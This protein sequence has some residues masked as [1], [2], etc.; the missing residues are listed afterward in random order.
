MTLG[1]KTERGDVLTGLR[2][3]PLS[4]EDRLLREAVQSLSL[5]V[6]KTGLDEAL[7]NLVSSHSCSCFELGLK[8]KFLELPSS[9]NYPVIY[10]LI[11]LQDCCI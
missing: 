4:H 5:E 2:E 10:L 7:S 11:L 8:W 9:L 6:F 3:K 1:A